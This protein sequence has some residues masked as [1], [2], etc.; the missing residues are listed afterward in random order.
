MRGWLMKKGP[1]SWKRRFCLWNPQT[2]TFSCFKDDEVQISGVFRL[3]ERKAAKLN[4]MDLVVE[5]AQSNA[6]RSVLCVAAP[7]KAELER[8]LVAFSATV[9]QL[10]L[11]Q[12]P[13]GNRCDKQL[14]QFEHDSRTFAFLSQP[15]E[16]DFPADTG[17]VRTRGETHQQQSVEQSL[18]CEV[19]QR[20]RELREREER[21]QQALGHQ[22]SSELQ[23]Q[24]RLQARTFSQAALQKPPQALS[25]AKRPTSA[26]G[27]GKMLYRNKKVGRKTLVGT[28]CAQQVDGVLPAAPA[29][30]VQGASL[31]VS[32]SANTNNNTGV[33]GCYMLKQ[34]HVV[35]SFKRRYFTFSIETTLTSSKYW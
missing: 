7:S 1:M 23:S 2:R 26:D 35:R 5:Q 24:P 3:P 30:R 18:G 33:F 31:D 14:S 27:S 8:W 15:V 9:P 29:V 20:V 28:L 22:G 32:T 12:H 25:A 13:S 6:P 11:T 21:Q 10:P 4:R 17:T 34:R 19:E 16:F